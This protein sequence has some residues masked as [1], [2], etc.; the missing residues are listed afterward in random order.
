MERSYVRCW[1]SCRTALLL[2]AFASH[3]ALADD[4]YSAEW[5]K[6]PVAQLGGRLH[7]VIVHFPI[8]LLMCAALLEMLRVLRGEGGGAA[9]AVGPGGAG[10]KDSLAISLRPRVTDTVRT[11]VAFGALGAVVA[12]FAG[13]LNAAAEEPSK[14]TA[15][16]L[17]FH[18]WTGIA[19]AV[20]GLTA[21][22]SA[23]LAR[24]T[25]WGWPLP[26]FR[27]ALLLAAAGVGIG[28]HLGGTLVY[29]EDY[30]WSVFNS[31]STGTVA[32]TSTEPTGAAAQGRGTGETTLG[33]E[34]L[35]YERD[36]Q[37]IFAAHCVNCHGPSR[38][39]GKLRLDNLNLT[40]ERPGVL[41]AGNADASEI[42]RRVSLPPDDESFMP[43]VG[44]PLTSQQIDTLRRWIN[45]LGGSPPVTVQRSFARTAPE[46][47]RPAGERSAS[48]GDASGKKKP[49]APPSESNHEPTAA[50]PTEPPAESKLTESQRA[51]RD[52]AVAAIRARGGL[53]LPLGQNSD[54]LEV[55]LGLIGQP[56]QDRDLDLLHGLEPVLRD[57]DLS[58]TKITDAGLV[59]LAGF[60]QLVHLNLSR[61]AVTDA[62]A[63]ALASIA[64]LE[65]LNLYGT[66]V[67][68]AGLPKLAR[69]AK[70]RRLYLWQ[71]KATQ[72]GVDALASAMPNVSIDFGLPPASA[73]APATTTA[74]AIRR[75]KCC[76]AAE[77]AGK[78]CDH[79]CCIE[80]A[81]AG[82][83]CEKCLAQ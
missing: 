80:A 37:P 4:I 78:T 27:L 59:G 8:A 15:T 42:I 2:V 35:D 33:A 39:K 1:R 25:R 53:A 68:D 19:A 75:P 55:R 67:S 12:A 79:A 14:T 26:T 72:A 58:G 3:P 36:I 40:L 41:V 54:L 60:P 31:P 44:D 34:I 56:V 9:V 61:T 13:W 17:F 48:G 49:E 20:L 52:A 38:Q 70:L 24:R 30:Y 51:A 81:K 65:Y 16:T 47:S 11:L 74:A 46:E 50:A 64:S 45:G 82:K 6:V 57:L 22:L 73:S 29:G 83:V 32:R 23:A 21:W 69:L 77:A 66:G 5:M 10:A 18:R 62:G 28:G 76:T 63:D 43:A 7:P 71:S